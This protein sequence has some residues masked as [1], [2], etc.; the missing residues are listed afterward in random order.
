MV[1]QHLLRVRAPLSIGLP[2]GGRRR[3]A[4]V[5]GLRALEMSR[6]ALGV[7]SGLIQR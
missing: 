5:L 7:C 4:W 3:I 2:E 6:L 1:Q